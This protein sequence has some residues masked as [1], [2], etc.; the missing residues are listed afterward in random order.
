MVTIHSYS[1]QLPLPFVSTG[2]FMDW[3]GELSS[4][5]DILNHKLT[6]TLDQMTI[7]EWTRC[8]LLTQTRSYK[9][10]INLKRVTKLMLI[11]G[12][13]IHLVILLLHNI[14]VILINYEQWQRWISSIG[15]GKHEEY[16]LS[17]P[18]PSTA[19]VS[20]SSVSAIWD[21]KWV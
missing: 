12:V 13:V 8:C 19:P 1:N 10:S 17:S 16:L 14:I 4:C 7:N 5:M 6:L 15:D 9:I 21:L 20:F 11:I 3:K 2:N 18:P